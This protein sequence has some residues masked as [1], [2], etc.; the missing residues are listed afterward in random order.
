MGNAALSQH[1][2]SDGPRWRPVSVRLSDVQV[3]EEIAASTKISTMTYVSPRRWVEKAKQVG[4]RKHSAIIIEADRS[5]CSVCGTQQADRK[6]GNSNCK[7]ASKK[8]RCCYCHKVSY[9]SLDCKKADRK[10]HRNVCEKTCL[11]AD[12]SACPTC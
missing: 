9:F 6:C 1:G 7:Q 8:L 5:E 11:E 4:I 12:R 10:D 3:A 2:H